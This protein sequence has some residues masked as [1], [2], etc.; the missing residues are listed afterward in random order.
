MNSVRALYSVREPRFDS[1]PFITS[2]TSS[3]KQEVSVTYFSW[4]KAIFGKYDLLHLHWPEDLFRTRKPLIRVI[5]Y[6][7]FLFLYIRIKTFRIPVL[8]TVHNNSPHEG[9]TRTESL[10][11]RLCMSMVDRRIFMSDAQRKMF[12]GS[13]AGAVIRHGHYK[14]S[15]PAATVAPRNTRAKTILYFG[16]VRRYKG[17][18]Q[19]AEAFSSLMETRTDK[20]HLVIAGRPNPSSYGTELIER[21]ASIGN[22]EWMLRFHSNEATSVLF[23]ESDL[24]VLPYKRMVNSGALLLGLSFGKPVLAPSNA[25]TREIRD[26][27][28]STWLHL[29]EGDLSA[30]DLE[31]ALRFAQ[32]DVGGPDLSK[33]EWDLL[34]KEYTAQYLGLIEKRRGSLKGQGHGS[35]DGR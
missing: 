1:N 25:V 13:D 6:T 17:V 16:F 5:K 30:D 28:G 35:Q 26:E 7:L 18:E 8:W 34:G 4:R 33:R 24:V 9:V 29:Y 2:L 21:Y 10:F 31:E 3:V 19:L 27:V 15:Y 14:G 22:I 20:V 12:S 32:G 23:A 11:L